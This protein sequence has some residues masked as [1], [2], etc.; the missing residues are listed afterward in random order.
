MSSIIL[1]YMLP[2]QAQAHVSDNY[3]AIPPALTIT[4]ERNQVWTLG[5]NTAPR[6]KSPDGEYAFD[7]LLNGKFVGEVASRIERRSGRIRIFTQD[8]WKRW[9]GT[10][11]I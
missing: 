8:G 5:F 9:S 1:D 2:S 7:V 6:S 11:F 3:V 10:I 4:D